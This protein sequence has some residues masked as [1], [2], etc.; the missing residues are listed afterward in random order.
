MM[1]TSATLLL[2]GFWFIVATGA[3]FAVWVQV[4]VDPKVASNK[5]FVVSQKFRSGPASAGTKTSTSKSA[6]VVGQ[7]LSPTMV[8]L[9]V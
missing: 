3:P 1:V 9:K 8:H 2:A 5:K 6:N 7:L 4:P